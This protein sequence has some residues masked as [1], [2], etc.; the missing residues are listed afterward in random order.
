[1]YICICINIIIKKLQEQRAVVSYVCVSKIVN[2]TIMRIITINTYHT[3]YI[4]GRCLCEQSAVGLN[5]YRVYV[6]I[7]FLSHTSY[8]LTCPQG[9]N[10]RFS[11]LFTVA[12]IFLLRNTRT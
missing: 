7:Y 4:N 12:F 6:Y 1:M 10:T 5:F 3:S 11:F 9:G 8:F 2:D